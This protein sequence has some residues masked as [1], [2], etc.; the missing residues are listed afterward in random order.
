VLPAAVLAIS[1]QRA[2]PN[3]PLTI[4]NPATIGIDHGN[5]RPKSMSIPYFRRN[6]LDRSN[7]SCGLY[8][9]FADRPIATLQK[10]P[11]REIE[12]KVSTN[13]LVFAIRKKP[14]NYLN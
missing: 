7:G 1:S 3:T 14:P 11:N 2:I 9:R 10:Q 6:A 4:N 12:A 8:D 13:Q 5:W